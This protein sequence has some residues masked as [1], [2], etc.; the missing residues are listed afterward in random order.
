MPSAWPV[1]GKSLLPDILDADSNKQIVA[2]W[3]YLE[4]GPRARIPAGLVTD[5]MELIPEDEPLIYRNFIQGAGPRAIAV[6]YPEA[7]NLAL[8]ADKMRLAL[9]WKGAFIDAKRHWTG[10]GQGFEAPQGKDVVS[11]NESSDFAKWNEGESWPNDSLRSAAIQFKGYRL[12]EERRPTFLYRMGELEI[13]DTFVPKEGAT[14]TTLVRSV[15]IRGNV[16][17]EGVHFKAAVANAIQAEADNW[18]ALDN[19]MRLRVTSETGSE[20][21]TARLAKLGSQQAVLVPITLK[22]GEASIEVEFD[23]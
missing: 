4:D 17:T 10:R 18:F 6:G 14:K 20:T 16:A 2:V 1:R 8:D 13:E 22:D 11:F 21:G 12:G 5:S 9:I 19:G 3:K 23:W 15:S 7:V